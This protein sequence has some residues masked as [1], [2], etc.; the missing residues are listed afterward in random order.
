MES[1][2]QQLGQQQVEQDVKPITPA[3]Q[4]AEDMKYSRKH[5]L[6]LAKYQRIF[7]VC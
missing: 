1:V 6:L 4:H 2:Q 7:N 3:E 5:Q